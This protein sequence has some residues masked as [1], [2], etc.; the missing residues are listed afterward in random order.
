MTPPP[1]H[2]QLIEGLRTA[3]GD[4][5]LITR[6]DKKEPYC[7]GFRFGSGAALAVVRPAT[8]VELWRSLVLCVEADVI[9][10]MQAANTGLTGASVPRGHEH[11]VDRP[12][13][14]LNMTRLDKIMPIDGGQRMVCLAG[15]GIHSVL[16]KA[17]RCA[18]PRASRATQCAT[19]CASRAMRR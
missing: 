17:Q 7:T 6:Q 9:V 18:M 2:R 15:A 5:N 11:G 8:L 19:Q 13:V 10:I 4:R 3:V 16:Q 1:T 14:V 12:T